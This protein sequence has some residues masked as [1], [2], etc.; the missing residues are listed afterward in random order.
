MPDSWDY[1][2]P[3]AR[4][5]SPPT[6]VNQVPVI[7]YLL[8]VLSVLFTLAFH[9]PSL[10]PGPLWNWMGHFSA[11]SSFAV[12]DG[13]YAGLVTCVFVH[14]SF[15]HILFNL[16]WLRQLGSAI[17]ATLPP[18]AYIAFLLLAAVV[19]SC[20]EMIV[21]GNTGIGMSG[22]VYALFGLM[23]VGRARY[24]HWAR[25]ATPENFKL[26][27]VWG[28]FCVIATY[29]H[30]MGIANGAHGAG[31]LFGLSVGG[32]FFTSQRRPLW[33]VSMIA[34]FAMAAVALT[35]MPW[36]GAWCWWKGNQAFEHKQYEQAIN[37]YQRS[38]QRGEEDGP[39]W[40]NI[41]AAWY[42]IGER[43]VQRRDAAEALRATT[44]LEKAEKTVSEIEQRE[45]AENAREAKPAESD[46]SD[47]FLRS[48]RHATPDPKP[49]N[50]Q[51]T[52]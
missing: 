51:D 6:P 31:F 8:C 10:I 21:S 20:G 36:S 23:W 22:V 5:P 49:G 39:L 46:S 19:G 24:P 33:A 15:F 45:E 48:L 35:W 37:W 4:Q 34:L 12:W 13:H 14:G 52:H 7:T 32:L 1:S 40:K 11:A 25:M 41:A 18:L 3:P 43:A 26:F 30:L 9:L 2:Q 29:T 42:E 28:L 27:V 50:P 47:N 16:L 17:E 38:L 44:Q